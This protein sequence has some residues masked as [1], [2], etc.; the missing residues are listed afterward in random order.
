MQKTLT[1][2]FVNPNPPQ[3]VE[4]ALKAVL[5]EKLLAACSD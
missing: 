3:V 1:F 2:T 4:A 5:L